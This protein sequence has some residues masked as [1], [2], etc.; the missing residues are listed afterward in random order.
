MRMDNNSS[1]IIINYA[2]CI[3]FF[4]ILVIT[5]L[6]NKNVHCLDSPS[7]LNQTDQVTEPHELRHQ[8]AER[9][10]GA[11]S[12]VNRVSESSNSE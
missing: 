12:G 7:S 8:V 11:R 3:S 2:N 5:L 9:S 4:A 10:S 1:S 6:G